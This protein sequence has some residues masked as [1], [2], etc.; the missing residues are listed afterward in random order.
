MF[1]TL[2]VLLP[3]SR[4]FDNHFGSRPL[5]IE[6]ENKLSVVS[7]RV[8]TRLRV[9]WDSFWHNLELSAVP[10][11]LIS[12]ILPLCTGPREWQHFNTVPPSEPGQFPST[13]KVAG[14]RI[15]EIILLEFS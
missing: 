9:E 15:G 10:F 12:G 3:L 7:D 13:M 1:S 2:P 11:V 14:N 6:I 4:L 5:R 8:L